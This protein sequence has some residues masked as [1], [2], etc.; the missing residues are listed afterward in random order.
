ML[1]H[2]AGATGLVKDDSIAER[3]IMSSSDTINQPV[4]TPSTRLGTPL[5]RTAEREKELINEVEDLKLSLDLHEDLNR[6]AAKALGKPFA[7]PRSSWHDIPEE[8]L[9]LKKE[10]KQLRIQLKWYRHERSE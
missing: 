8:I 4:A 2:F 10:I 1:S 9:Q 5:S 3:K 6:R 7:G